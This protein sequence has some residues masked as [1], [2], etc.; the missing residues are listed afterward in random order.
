MGTPGRP[1]AGME[2]TSS[3]TLSLDSASSVFCSW[4][5]STSS[6]SESSTSSMQL[7]VLL[8]SS[9]TPSSSSCRFVVELC[10]VVRG[11]M[12]SSSEFVPD[13]ALSGLGLGLIGVGLSALA[14]R[15]LPV[16]IVPSEATLVLRVSCLG[17]SDRRT[18]T[19]ESC[20]AI[21]LTGP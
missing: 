4:S 5:Q 13:D 10:V 14:N 11:L 7:I 17:G 20:S 8:S 21:F 6:S 2:L 19:S 12:T 18:V 15:L 1:E 3:E 9:L 16:V